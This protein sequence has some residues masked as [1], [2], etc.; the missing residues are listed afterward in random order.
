MLTPDKD[1]WWSTWYINPSRRTE[2]IADEGKR[3]LLMVIVMVVLA[4]TFG[5]PARI[6]EFFIEKSRANQASQEAQQRWLVDHARG[7]EQP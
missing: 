1:S 5:G 2:M 4:C 6:K 3:F 7:P